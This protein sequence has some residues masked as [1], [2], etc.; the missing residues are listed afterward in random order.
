[1]AD[2][3]FAHLRIYTRYRRWSRR[4]K[5]ALKADYLNVIIAVAAAKVRKPE[6][7]VRKQGRRLMKHIG[8]SIGPPEIEQ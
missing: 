3:K 6:R 1:M 8:F 5:K 2:S 4:R 7:D